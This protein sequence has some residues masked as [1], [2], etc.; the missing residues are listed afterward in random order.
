MNENQVI[1]LQLSRSV[2]ILTF[3]RK[4]NVKYLRKFLMYIYLY[5]DFTADGVCS[6]H[7]SLQQ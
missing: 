4:T 1:Q 5:S 2:T 3:K 7:A 6:W